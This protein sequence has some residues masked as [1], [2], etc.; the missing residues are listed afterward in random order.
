MDFDYGLVKTVLSNKRV[1]KDAGITV[2]SNN[3]TVSCQFSCIFV[4][5]YL[6]RALWYKEKRMNN[7][8]TAVN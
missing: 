7:G 5:L 6:L 4:S 2:W 1:K 3:C 8:E